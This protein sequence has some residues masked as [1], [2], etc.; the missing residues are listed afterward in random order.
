V[1][2]QLGFLLLALIW[3]FD[4]SPFMVLIIAILND[5]MSPY[6]IDKN[7]NSTI[8]S[9]TEMIYTPCGAICPPLGFGQNLFGW[10][11]PWLSVWWK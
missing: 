5:G 6:T 10:T 2:F 9:S 4:F 3:K 7:I 1:G 11:S 8:H